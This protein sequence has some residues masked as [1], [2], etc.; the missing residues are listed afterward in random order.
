MLVQAPK[1]L[2]DDGEIHLW[3]LSTGSEL[4][5]GLDATGRTL[6]SVDENERLAGI[7]NLARARQFVA[8]RILLRRVLGGYLSKDPATIELISSV[9]GKL[10]IGGAELKPVF[11]LSHAGD[12]TVLAVA[13]DGDIGVDIEPL[14]RAPATERIALEFFSPAENRYLD[15]QG[16]GRAGKALILWAI[17]EAIVKARGDTVWDGL[18]GIPLTIEDGRIGWEA[19]PPDQQ[20][21]RLS[22]GEFDASYVIAVAHRVPAGER[23]EALSFRNYDSSGA[24][25]LQ[26]AFESVLT[27]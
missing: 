19:Q 23:A 1:V 24:P 12:Q 14:S 5:A 6:L 7:K 10:S 2:P 17:K 15:C 27:D 21:W 20:H 9:N 11:S 3:H 8:G 25:A 26:G 4:P 13:G 16:E 22:A 18:A